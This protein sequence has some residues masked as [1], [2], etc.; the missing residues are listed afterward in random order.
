MRI[1]G[2]NQSKS[3]KFQSKSGGKIHRRLHITLV[4]TY[5][6]IEVANK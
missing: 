3:N 4:D 1:L 6:K 5:E 2:K